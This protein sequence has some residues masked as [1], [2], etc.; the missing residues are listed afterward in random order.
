[1]AGTGAAIGL[2]VAV[3]T[4]RFLESQV[5]GVSVRDVYVFMSA[6]AVLGFVALAASLVPGVTGEPGRSQYV[7]A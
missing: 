6:A 3:A 2:V 1:M 5:Y 4:S 7:A